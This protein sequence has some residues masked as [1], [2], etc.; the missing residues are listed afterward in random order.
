LVFN[1]WDE[2][3]DNET[4]VK[5]ASVIGEP[6]LSRKNIHNVF[7]VGLSGDTKIEMI[8]GDDVSIKNIKPGMLLKNGSYVYGLV[9]VKGSDLNQR[10]FNL[11]GNQE[12]L[13]LGSES[14]DRISESTLDKF[15]EN[16]EKSEEKLYHLLTDS[17]NFYINNVLFN[18]YNSA[19][20]LFLDKL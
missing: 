20:E 5:L 12:S 11:G 7:D 17:G 8:I 4:V 13:V 14:L 15:C 19:I 9:E 3:Y 16:L 1:D 10:L 6:C 2:I 18:D